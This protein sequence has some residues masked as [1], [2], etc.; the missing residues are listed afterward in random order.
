MKENEKRRFLKAQDA[1]LLKL[2]FNT[3]LVLN[4]PSVVEMN[5]KMEM[6]YLQQICHNE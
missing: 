1:I 6:L 5:L 4:K 3:E 2:I